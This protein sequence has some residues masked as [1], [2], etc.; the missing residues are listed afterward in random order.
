MADNETPFAGLDPDRVLDA[1]EAMGLDCDGR[2]LALNSY[3]NRV[4]RVGVHDADPVVA[5]FYRPGRWSDDAI[6]E[7]HA[8]AMELAE[9]DVPVVPPLGINGKTLHHHDGQRIALFPLR[10]GHAPEL[11][12]RDSLTLLGRVL[13]R[14]HAVG[15]Q[16][17]FRHRLTL[18]IEGFGRR[19][20]QTLLDC[21]QLPHNLRDNLQRIGESL[22]SAVESRWSES[23][24]PAIIRLHGDCHP[25]NILRRDERLHF[26]DLDDCLNGPA[27]QDLWM[28]LSG[29]RD[30]QS[31]QLDWLLEG[32]RQFHHFNARELALI[33][34]LRA[35]RLLHFN[36]WL[37]RRWHDPAFP[38]AFPWFGEN[39]HWESLIGQL[40]EQLGELHEPPIELPW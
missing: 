31:R 16:R 11:D 9:R 33:E 18:D 40:Q 21:G 10:G 4:F 26:V 17:R 14:L 37:A 32:Y 36:A 23:G 20:L 25:G 1:L 30:D 3:E 29:S 5:K 6:L 15:E 8:F 12:D 7:E 22:L 35:L 27:M 2:V 38:A 34:P 28:L 13:G 19:S 24:Q 39:R